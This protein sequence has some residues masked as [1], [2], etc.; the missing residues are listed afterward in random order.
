MVLLT[1][2]DSKIVYGELLALESSELNE[3]TKYPEAASLINESSIHGN[4]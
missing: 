3:D 4:R 1:G 2:A